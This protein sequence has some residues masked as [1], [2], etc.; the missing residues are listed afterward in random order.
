MM[1]PIFCN[2]EQKRRL[3]AEKKMQEKGAK[4]P[5]DAKP[6]VQKHDNLLQEGQINDEE[7]DPNVSF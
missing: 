5:A 2:S 3:K 4:T 7:I 1:K 6:A